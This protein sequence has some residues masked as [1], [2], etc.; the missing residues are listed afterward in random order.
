MIYGRR[1]SLSGEGGAVMY[2]IIDLR[3]SELK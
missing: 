1:V 2:I 3:C